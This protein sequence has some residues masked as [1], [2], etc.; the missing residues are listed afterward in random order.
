MRDDVSGA[1]IILADVGKDL[2]DLVEIR[3]ILRE[4]QLRGA[5]IV[6]NGPERLV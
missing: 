3:R 2:P 1:L 4:Q 6:E 5:D